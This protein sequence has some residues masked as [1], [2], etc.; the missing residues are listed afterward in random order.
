MLKK[1][2][3]VIILAGK[4]KG[5]QGEVR[6]VI[7]AK[8]RVIVTGVNMITKHVKPT[9]NKKGGIQKMEAPLDMSNV[10]LFCPNCK[11]GVR[12]GV[13]IQDNGDKTRICRKCSENI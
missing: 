12:H 2:D 4:D 13:K 11:K 7:N 5:K 1:N 8:N 6:E 3:K 10:A 9:G